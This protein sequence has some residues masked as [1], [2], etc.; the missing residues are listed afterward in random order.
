MTEP[1]PDASAPGAAPATPTPRKARPAWKKLAIVLASFLLALPVAEIAMRVVLAAKGHAYD[2]GAT[3]EKIEKLLDPIRRFVPAGIQ[4][5]DTL[6]DGNPVPILHPYTGAESWHDTGGV[7]EYFR[8]NNGADEYKIVVVGGSVASLF[9]NDATDRLIQLLSQDPALRGRSI[10]VLNY[11]HPS[12]KQPQ[13]LNRIT[14]LLALGAKFDAVIN[15]DGF[16]EVGLAYENSHG[17]THPV[18]PSAPTWAAA[19]ADFGVAGGKQLM[20]AVQMLNLR[21]EARETIERALRWHFSSS[22]ILGTMTLQRLN[23]INRRRNELQ[24]DI[25]TSAE[26]QPMSKRILRQINGP[27]FPDSD[28]QRMRICVNA[29]YECSLSLDAVCRARGIHYLHVLQP[30]LGDAG[31]KPLSDAEKAIVPPSPD[32]M[33]GPRIGYP[34]LRRMGEQLAAHGVHFADLSYAFEKETRTFYF[35]PCHFEPPANRIL[36]ERVAREFRTMLTT[37]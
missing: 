24:K 28:Q 32:W 3:Q 10:R 18:Y 1:N 21:D 12:Y 13:Q 11:A 7:L 37:K 4:P 17:W 23:G 9:V 29:W 20:V 31:S 22:A 26:A 6:P 14:Y 27:D 36:A 25:T 15:M 33:E 8:K 30:C 16:N 2:A 5:T 35:D 19:A 34:V